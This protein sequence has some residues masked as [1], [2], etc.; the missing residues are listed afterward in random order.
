MKPLLPLDQ[1]LKICQGLHIILQPTPR[2]V[3]LWPDNYVPP[4]LKQTIKANRAEVRKLVLQGDIRTCVNPDLHRHEW[5]Y[6]SNQRY[7]CGICERLKF[8]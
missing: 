5:R 6:S 4:V 2:S 1:A 7:I 8:C 3:K